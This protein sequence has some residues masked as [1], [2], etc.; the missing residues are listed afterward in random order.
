VLKLKEK[1][2]NISLSFNKSKTFKKI[3]MKYM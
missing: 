1:D 2:T 3:L